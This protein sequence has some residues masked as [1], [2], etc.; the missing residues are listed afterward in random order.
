[1]ETIALLVFVNRL[2]KQKKEK[3]HTGLDLSGGANIGWANRS[4]RLAAQLPLN[5]S[6]QPATH[7]GPSPHAC[8]IFF[9][10]L[11]FVQ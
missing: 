3:V 5:Y 2:K 4:I 11:I 10:H 7:A 8:M 6:V 1:M 9:I